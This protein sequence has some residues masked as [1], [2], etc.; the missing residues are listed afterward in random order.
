MLFRRKIK[1]FTVYC[2]TEGMGERELGGAGV[3]EGEVEGSGAGRGEARKGQKER[4][5]A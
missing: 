3:R 2:F 1:Y 4:K 5:R